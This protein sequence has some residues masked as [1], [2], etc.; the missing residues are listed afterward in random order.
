MYSNW[1]LATTYKLLLSYLT[2]FR[3]IGSLIASKR[4]R[5]NFSSFEIHRRRSDLA[6]RNPHFLLYLSPSYLL[7]F[8][9][10]LRNSLRFLLSRSDVLKNFKLNYNFVPDTRSGQRVEMAFG[11]R[12]GNLAFDRSP[13]V[14]RSSLPPMRPLARRCGNARRDAVSTS[15]YCATR[16]A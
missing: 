1:H 4:T 10:D 12:V 6:F 11:S 14:Q 9:R 15:C 2:V 13:R 8:S 7:V 16:R 5:G 3:V